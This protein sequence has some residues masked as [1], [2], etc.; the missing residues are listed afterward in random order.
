MKRSLLAF[1][2]ILIAG[3]ATFLIHAVVAMDA[4]SAPWLPQ[5]V[6]DL[7]PSEFSS[8]V[9]SVLMRDEGV[10]VVGADAGGAA[11]AMQAVD[12][13]DAADMPNVEVRVS[14][15]D[16]A[17]RALFTWSA[18]GQLRFVALP[19]NAIGPDVLRLWPDDGWQGRIDAVGVA[20]APVDYLHGAQV[21]DQKFG[22]ERLSVRSASKAD[23]AWG[24]LAQW[25]AP[26]LWT[27]RSPNT[28]GF[29]L[30]SR[31]MPSLQVWLLLWAL[32]S[33]AI[34]AAFYGAGSVP[35]FA[36][37][38]F[39]T[40]AIVLAAM[41]GWQLISRAGRVQAAAA[42][43]AR[44]PFHPLATSPQLAADTSEAEA[45]LRRRFGRARVAVYG[46]GRFEREY[47]TWGLRLHDAATLDSSTQLESGG[48]GLDALVLVGMPPETYDASAGELRLDARTM[49]AIPL[50]HVGTLDVYDLSTT[51]AARW[52]R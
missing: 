44:A 7:E 46:P 9:S 22:L 41:Q 33:T 34:V 12:I 29:E 38:A 47:V 23:A 19:S 14:G 2:S 4:V 39:I 15:I 43:A 49:H 16:P 48:A 26:R 52:S 24:L 30:G 28:A 1:A 3:L 27:G 5:H 17:S 8:P 31:P 13:E 20:V 42:H 10:E 32:V 45:V 21:P 11:L 36:V 51:E 25:T 35:G 6:L 50:L 37:R 40:I 18:G